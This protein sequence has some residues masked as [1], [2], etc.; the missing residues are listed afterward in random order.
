VPREPIFKKVVGSE[1]GV[2]DKGEQFAFIDANAGDYP[3]TKLV[4][5]TSVSRSGYYKWKAQKGRNAQDLKDEELLPYVLKIFHDHKGTYGRK[6]IKLALR[7]QYNMQVNE[8]RI[9]RMM[10]KYGLWCKIRKKRFKNRTQPHG[11]IPNLL[12]RNFIALKP[13]VKFAIDITYVEVKKGPQR[14]LYVCA[15]KDLFNQEIVAYSRG[16]SQ[17]VKLVFQALNELKQNGFV[18]GA[19]LHSDQGFQFT[20]PGYRKHLKDMGLTQSMSRRGNCWDNACI[21]NFFGHLKCEMPCFSQP[22]TVHEVQ[23]AVDAYIQYYNHN[24]IQTKL[25]MSPNEFRKKAA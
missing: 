20:N 23:D 24:R 8:K 10:R 19:L 11:D 15:I 18:K 14:W 12:D 21:E 9:S 7:N 2:N 17:E 3:I 16:T 4:D 25:Q 6:R 1:K 22:E 5:I 13:G